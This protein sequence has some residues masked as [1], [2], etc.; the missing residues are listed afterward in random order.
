MKHFVI[1]K[2]AGFVLALFEEESREAAKARL[3]DTAAIMKR[4]TPKELYRASHESLEDLM[5]A[6]IYVR[7]FIAESRVTE[8]EAALATEQ[9][10]EPVAPVIRKW[11]N[12]R[13][14]QDKK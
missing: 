1:L 11:A 12:G 14:R 5:K 3:T 6:D 4:M 13:V 2:E 8:L 7:L 10:K 9:G